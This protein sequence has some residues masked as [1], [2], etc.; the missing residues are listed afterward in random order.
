MN[1]CLKICRNRESTVLACLF[2]E[3]DFPVGVRDLDSGPFNGIS[4]DVRHNSFK[5][6]QGRVV[7]GNRYSRETEPVNANQNEDE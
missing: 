5:E 6:G 3:E 4:D 7:L 1:G 2:P